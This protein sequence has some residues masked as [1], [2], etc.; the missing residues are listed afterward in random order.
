[1]S[2][3]STENNNTRT[4][5]NNNNIQTGRHYTVKPSP[6]L[7][8][9]SGNVASRTENDDDSPI[10]LEARLSETILSLRQ[11]IHTNQQ[12]DEALLKDVQDDD[13]LEALKENDEL[14]A[15]RMKDV[16][17]MSRRLKELGVQAN[18][19]EEDMPVY[20]GSVVLKKLEEVKR[21]TREEECQLLEK[22]ESGGLYL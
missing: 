18:F 3:K 4:E 5:N 21:R 12:L 1:M 8:T 13:L 17:V 16:T 22:E 7:H 11:L 15:R 9:A 20:G 10:L 2:N 19:L 14:I 6:H